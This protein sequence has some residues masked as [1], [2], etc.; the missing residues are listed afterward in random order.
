MNRFVNHFEPKIGW[1]NDP[2]GLVQFR[3]RY[4][5]FFQHYPHDTVWGPMHWGHAVSDDLIHWEELPIAL[6]PDQ[7]YENDGGCFSGSAIVHEDKLYLIY[8]SVGKEL[9]QTQS[10][11]VSED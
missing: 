5:A 10:I 4:H 8:T 1:M 6:Y 3:G 11:A 9:G 2:N 7:E